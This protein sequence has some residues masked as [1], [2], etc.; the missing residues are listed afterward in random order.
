MI[1]NKIK[2]LREE[3]GINQEDLA[4]RIN[5]SASSV[6]MYETNKRQ[7]NYETLTKL[8]D[9]F[10]VSTDYLLGITTERNIEINIAQSGG[11]DTE[12]LSDEELEEV[13]KQIEYMKWKKN[14]NK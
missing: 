8:A 7:P 14:N 3:L 2:K 13:K 9:L 4:K 6:A 1:G 10:N 12:G 5:V 11:L